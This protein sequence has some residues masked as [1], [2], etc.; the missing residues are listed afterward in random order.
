VAVLKGRLCACG[1]NAFPSGSPLGTYGRVKTAAGHVE[2]RP[3]QDADETSYQPLPSFIWRRR[4]REFV[5][6]IGNRL[7][8][9]A[10]HP[11]AD[12]DIC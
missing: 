3:R 4:E 12:L 11:S 8:I 6:Y 9:S 7:N 2:I 1:G 5:L 10:I